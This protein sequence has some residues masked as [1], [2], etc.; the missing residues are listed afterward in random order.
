[1]T[2]SIDLIEKISQI[3]RLEQNYSFFSVHMHDCNSFLRNR[4]HN[5]I[6]IH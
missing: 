1:M 3:P 5:I 2:Y 6:F 4:W